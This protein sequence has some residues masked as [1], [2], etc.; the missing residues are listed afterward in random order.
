MGTLDINKLK[1]EPLQHLENM[2]LQQ[3]MMKQVL[4]SKAKQVTPNRNRRPLQNSS[5]SLTATEGGRSVVKEL[6]YLV[7]RRRHKAT[8]CRKEKQI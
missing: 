3:A 7:T 2:M 8:V 6:S 1:L 4:T 5:N